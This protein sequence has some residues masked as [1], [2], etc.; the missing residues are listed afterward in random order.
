MYNVITS[1][2]NSDDLSIGFRRSIEAQKEKRLAIKQ[3]KE[4]I[5]LEF[6]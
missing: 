1:S 2:R 4:I 5:M 6:F 3:L